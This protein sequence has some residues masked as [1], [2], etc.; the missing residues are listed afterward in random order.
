MKILFVS[1]GNICTSPLAEGIL[2]Y[3]LKEKKINAT[4][5]SAGFESYN[6]NETPNEEVVNFAKKKGIDIS[7]NRCRLFVS[8]DFDKFDKI[9]VADSASYRDVQFFA[10]DEKEMEKVEYLLGVVD[11]TN[12]TVPKL[13]LEGEKGLVKLFDILDEA[14]EIIANKII[15]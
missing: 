15:K 6:I 8:E 12:K 1:L 4:V 7:K 5:E 14:T 11:G 2:K 3:K 13:F 9:Y 10:R